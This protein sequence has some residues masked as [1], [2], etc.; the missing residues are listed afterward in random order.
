LKKRSFSGQGQSPNK[1]KYYI[2]IDEKKGKRSYK[3]EE[4][5]QY[6]YDLLKYDKCDSKYGYKFER[7]EPHENKPYNNCDG[8]YEAIFK[9]L[10]YR[11][12]PKLAWIFLYFAIV[13]STTFLL[14]KS[15]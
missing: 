3:G 10:W 2:E 8:Y 9:E 4:I 6:V 5:P 11:K 14:L 1:K 15:D 7:W 12:V 13:A